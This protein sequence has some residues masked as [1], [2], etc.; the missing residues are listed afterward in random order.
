MTVVVLLNMN[1]ETP[2]WRHVSVSLS[3]LVLQRSKGSE[4]F[5]FYNCGAG[6][7]NTY[8]AMA[9]HSFSLCSS[10]RKLWITLQE[11][12]LFQ[13]CN[14]NVAV[15]SNLLTY[16]LR[17]T[18]G[19]KCEVWGRK[20]FV[21]QQPH[22]QHPC[23]PSKN[24]DDNTTMPTTRSTQNPNFHYESVWNLHIR[25]TQL[26]TAEKYTDVAE[27]WIPGKTMYRTRSGIQ[28]TGHR[29]SSRRHPMHFA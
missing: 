7:R 25:A 8:S 13:C 23:T 26:H 10:I 21:G 29:S 2:Q 24:W 9:Q 5:S 18:V 1:S 16:E 4:T 14:R 22:T 11:L 6:W 3:L 12:G 17:L 27:L 28:V 15:N 19:V 20:N